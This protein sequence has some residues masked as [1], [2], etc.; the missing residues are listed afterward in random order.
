MDTKQ[1][2]DAITPLKYAKAISNVFPNLRPNKTVGEKKEVIESRDIKLEIDGEDKSVDG[3]FTKGTNYVPIRFLEEIG[4]D[5]GWDK[6]SK[7]V[8][9]ESLKDIKLRLNNEDLKV[10]GVF[11]QSQNYIPVRFLEE[12]GYDIGWD[13]E[14]RV[15]TITSKN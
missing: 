14:D 2:M 7:K 5:V 4:Y 11:K 10:K 9:A 1:D 6:V 15:V 12:L 13:N 8:V 3:L